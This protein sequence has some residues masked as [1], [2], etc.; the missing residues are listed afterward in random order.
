MVFEMEQVQSA[1]QKA[2]AAAFGLESPFTS[3]PAEIRR[4]LVDR[5]RGVYFINLGGG[6]ERPYFLV[7]AGRNGVLLQAEALN[8][9][10]GEFLPKGITVA[11][12]FRS[13]VIPKREAERAEEIL[14]L[15]NESLQAYGYLGNAEVAS[16]ISVAMVTPSFV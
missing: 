16:S 5:A 1:A 12:S 3:G 13:I 11:W 2:E 8:K 6:G 9:A 15:L 14:A 7:L 4:W 10:D